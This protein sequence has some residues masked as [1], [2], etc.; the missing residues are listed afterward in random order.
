MF[1]VSGIE[2]VI[3]LCEIEKHNF[4]DVELPLKGLCDL[5]A[6]FSIVSIRERADVCGDVEEF[7][8]NVLHMFSA[9]LPRRPVCW[10]EK[11]ELIMFADYIGT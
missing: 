5:V 8:C 1:S 9:L 4:P 2:L 7:T 10:K 3:S 6:L 11:P